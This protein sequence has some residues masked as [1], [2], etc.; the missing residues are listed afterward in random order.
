MKEYQLSKGR[1]VKT[2]KGIGWIILPQLAYKSG[3]KNQTV[4]NY[5]GIH[6][7]YPN[8]LKYAYPLIITRSYIGSA[9]SVARAQ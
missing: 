4:I 2:L 1:F 9:H 7:I 8:I 5:F 6:K 3:V